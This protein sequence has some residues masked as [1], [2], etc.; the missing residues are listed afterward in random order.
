LLAIYKRLLGE[1][2]SQSGTRTLPFSEQ[3]D[4][5][6]RWLTIERILTGSVPMP[7][8][9]RD[10]MMEEGLSVRKNASDPP[11]TESSATGSNAAGRSR[12]KVRTDGGGRKPGKKSRRVHS[13]SRDWV[14]SV[15]LN[16]HDAS[17]YG[18]PMINGILDYLRRNPRW[19]IPVVADRAFLSISQLTKWRGDGI[20]GE[21]YN[22]EAVRNISCLAIPAVNTT[23]VHTESSFPTVFQM[24]VDNEAVGI[25][26][27]DHLSTLG[28]SDYLF[29][30]DKCEYSKVRY[31][32]FRRRINESGGEVKAFWFAEHSRKGNLTNAS[33]YADILNRKRK[34]LA[35][36][37]STDRIALGVL[38][39]CRESECSVPED[40]AILGCDN[41][42]IICQLSDPGISSIDWDPFRVGFKAAELLDSIM[43]GRNVP[44]PPTPGPRLKVVLR[45]STDLY[46]SLDRDLSTALMFI[47]QHSTEPI[48]VPDVVQACGISRRK[49]ENLF[50]RHLNR[51]IYEEILSHHMKNAE[52]LLTDTTL[53]LAQIARQSGFNS[54]SALEAAV[55]RRHGCYAVEFRSRNSLPE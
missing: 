42:G 37:A 11:K 9:L 8:T 47:R 31:A 36:F 12:R 19:N 25:L 30:G 50:N 46:A 3:Q 53:P 41:E 29:I 1:G 6:A 23:G 33:L 54:V 15:A 34:P 21:F 43:R 52:H 32:A 10:I 22:R 49:L 24:S 13:L 48:Y 28:R 55:K 35:I 51:G 18:R 26:A 5:S 20:I 39:A 40:V 16:I 17:S 38:L 45:G 4:E 44:N 7:P 14:P 27:A 2:S